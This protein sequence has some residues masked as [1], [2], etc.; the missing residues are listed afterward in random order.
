MVLLQEEKERLK[1]RSIEQSRKNKR[2]KMYSKQH[3]G[4]AKEQEIESLAKETQNRTGS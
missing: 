1:R 3:Q 2:D 4:K